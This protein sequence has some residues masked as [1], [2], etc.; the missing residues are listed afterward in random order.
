MKNPACE[1][2]SKKIDLPPAN[3][4]IP[5][6]FDILA[7]DQEKSSKP[8][9]LKQWEDTDLWYK[10]DDKFERPKAIVSFKMYTTDNDFGQTAEARMFMTVW[11]SVMME[12]MREFNYTAECANLEFTATVLHDNLNCVWSGFND[13]M[14][15]YITETISRLQGM[16]DKDLAEEF[17]QVKE[18][19]MLEWKNSYLL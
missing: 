9:L 19:L 1:I 10:K 15:N 11:R 16:K 2:K 18:K 13:S 4:L 3:T 8:M 17:A 12:Y 7:K 6:N 5:K 14:P